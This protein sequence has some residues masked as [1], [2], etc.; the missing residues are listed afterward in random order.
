LEGWESNEGESIDEGHGEL[1]PRVAEAMPEVSNIL[2][3]VKV[4]TDRELKVR[5][6][7]Q[8]F[9]WVVGRA[10]GV[11]ISDGV[12]EKVGYPGRRRVGGT[13]VISFYVL[14]GTDYDSVKGLIK[15]KKDVSEGVANIL[16]GVSPAGGHAE[17]L[18]ERG[19]LSL[20]FKPHG[21][22]VSEFR[23]RKVTGVVGKEP[24]NVDFVFER[25]GLTYGVD[26][27]NWI[28]Y[29]WDTRDDVV[30]KVKVARKLGLVP[31]IIA[32][33][34][35]EDIAYNEIIKRGGIVYR[36]G[37]LL[38]PTLYGSVAD[39]A[40]EVLGY[41]VLATEELPAYKVKWME[42]LHLQRVGREAV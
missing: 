19:F 34:V 32:R 20:G 29:E 8:F 38:V 30:S 17:D 36:Y 37:E 24:P 1:D 4:A 40:R 18:F 6:E 23:N 33:Y 26:V 14:S 15:R 13:D 9:P 27:K 31:F 28:R 5:L 16:T 41:P 22:D 11:L 21:R 2:G 35:D 12:V 25:D 39:A 7:K 42:M 10:L 3:Q